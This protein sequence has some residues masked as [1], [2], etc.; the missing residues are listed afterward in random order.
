MLKKYFEFKEEIFDTIKSFYIHPDLN[1][2]IWTNED[3]DSTT[4]LELIEIAKDYAT[5]IQLDLEI[6]TDIILTGSLCGFNYSKYSDFDVHILIDYKNVNSDVDM[7]KRYLNYTKRLWNME[8]NI[9]IKGYDVELYCQDINEKHV[10]NGQYSLLRNEWI[11]KPSKEAHFMDE[12]LIKE[13]AELIMSIIDDIELS[14]EKGHK[15]KELEPQ[16]KMISKKISDNRKAGLEKEGEHSVENLVFKLLRRNGY[17]K[18]L[19][20]LK[21]K[22]YDS[23]FN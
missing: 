12:Q 14:Y 11:K 22:I 6:I 2:D 20:D 21:I 8:H 3:I 17:I 10:S 15:Y 19:L 16:I 18:K 1:E 4:R 23:Q 7:V 9:T 5:S 13:K